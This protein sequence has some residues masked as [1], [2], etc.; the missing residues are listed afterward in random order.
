MAALLA[1]ANIEDIREYFASTTGHT[2]PMIDFYEPFLKAYNSK[3]RDLR[4]VYYTPQ[5][6][7][8]YIVRS[9][10]R[11]LQDKF[12]KPHGLADKRTLVLDPATG[13]GSFLFSVI[14]RIHEEVSKSGS[15]KWGAYVEEHLLHR[16]F[17]FELMVAPYSIAHLKLGL[18]L[19]GLGAPVQDGE[20][21]GV[22]LTNTLDDAIK[23]A[24]SMFAKFVSDEA[25]AAAFIKIDEPILVVLGNPPYSGISANASKDAEGKL[26]KIGK[27]IEEYKW[28]DGAPLGEHKHWL[29]D[30]YVKFIAFAQDRIRKTGEGVVG[31]IT[32]HGYLDNPTFRGMRQSLMQTF[33]EIYV[34]DLH[35]NAKKKE[36]AP[37]GGKDENVFE[38]MQGVAILLAVKEKATTQSPKFS[39]PIYGASRKRST[40]RFPAAMFP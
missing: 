37:D 23:Q 38:I 4:G 35:G 33:N 8:G 2:D 36:R 11:L 6:V 22:Y 14:D 5:P 31:F 17:G 1:N 40:P 16:I 32:N 3:L 27:L 9:I 25:N 30:D 20:R 29:Q 34:L 7:V 19:A 12:N 18:Q 10:H 13:T 26:N 24:N 15:G 39:T 21:F 28:V